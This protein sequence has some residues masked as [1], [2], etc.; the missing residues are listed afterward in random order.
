MF[1]WQIWD[2]NLIDNSMI[3]DRF[4]FK[5]WQYIQSLAKKLDFFQT[6]FGK[7]APALF[8]PKVQKCVRIDCWC[9]RHADGDVVLPTA[10]VQVAAGI[11]LVAA[12]EA[13]A[14]RIV[15]KCVC[16]NV[17]GN[18]CESTGLLFAIC[19]EM[20]GALNR[21][22]PNSAFPQEGGADTGDPRR[23]RPLTPTHFYA[24]SHPLRSKS[25]MES[26]CIYAKCITQNWIL[27]HL[28]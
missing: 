7:H 17:Y 5:T 25:K 18:V 26:Q 19:M 1:S 23:R 22:L 14:S 9:G 11:E 13:A 20:H 16:G 28:C 3:G 6:Q 2:T 21:H 4:Q 24:P 27:I 12:E 8:I 10:R 15:S